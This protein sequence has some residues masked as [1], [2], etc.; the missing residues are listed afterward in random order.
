MAAPL[1]GT[2]GRPQPDTRGGRGLG[3]DG[4]AEKL[5]LGADT[6]AEW[7]SGPRLLRIASSIADLEALDLHRRAHDLARD[8]LHCA[9]GTLRPQAPGLLAARHVAAYRT[10]Q[11]GDVREARRLT[12]TLLDDCRDALGTDHPLTRTA[13]LRLAAWTTGSG[14]PAQGR[15]LYRE[16]VLAGPRD[17]ITLLARLGRAHADLLAGEAE[18]AVDRLGHLL[19]D[20]RAEHAGHH[21]VVLAARIHEAQAHRAGGRTA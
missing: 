18:E 12:S 9:E 1:G 2:G 11:T 15:R 5:R 21:P 3:W 13:L 10:G 19:P 8:L 16:L 6:E 14:E 4:A 17:R 7:L 20:L